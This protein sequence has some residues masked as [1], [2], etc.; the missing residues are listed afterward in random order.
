[1]QASIF[2]G[3][4]T[5]FLHLIMFA[6]VMI[7][8]LVASPVFGQSVNAYMS[9]VPENDGDQTQIFVEI[10]TLS[11]PASNIHSFTIVFKADGVLFTGTSSYTFDGSN[12]WLLGSDYT[13]DQVISSDSSE[14]TLQAWRKDQVEQSGYGLVGRGGQV[15]CDI[16][17]GISKTS[18]SPQL[19][20]VDFRVNDYV[21]PMLV[22][23]NPAG[24][25]LNVQHP[26][27]K[28]VGKIQLL[29][30]H[31]AIIQTWQTDSDQIRLTLPDLPKGYYILR[32]IS[33]GILQQQKIRL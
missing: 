7:A 11:E 10:G 1:M 12:G 26:G 4:A 20:V 33:E 27:A 3:K 15:I 16:D 22:G 19:R 31:G 30:L 18:N 14:I 21:P 2:T 8:A 28:A 17:D 25:Y 32:T 29:N 5:S 9:P 23:P 6:I 24:R 13:F